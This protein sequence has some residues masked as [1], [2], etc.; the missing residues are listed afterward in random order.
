[1]NEAQCTLNPQEVS[2]LVLLYQNYCSCAGPQPGRSGAKLDEHA[3]D[4]TYRTK[5][6]MEYADSL[7]N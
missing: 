3:P 1:M 4:C 5:A 2:R 7:Q 6:E